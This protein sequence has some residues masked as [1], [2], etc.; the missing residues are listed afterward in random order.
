MAS[1]NYPVLSLPYEV[2]AEVFL[3]VPINQIVTVCRRVSKTWKSFIDDPRLWHF[4]LKKCGNF[5]TKLM[6]VLPNKVC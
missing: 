2:V 4:M 3:C 5:K 1:E 6:E